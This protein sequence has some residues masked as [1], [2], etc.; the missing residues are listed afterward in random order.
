MNQRYTIHLESFLRLSQ[1]EINGNIDLPFSEEL[2][3]AVLTI[4]KIC[5][6]ELAIRKKAQK[7]ESVRYFYNK[8]VDNRNDPRIMKALLEEFYDQAQ[9]I[10][11]D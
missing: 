11:N 2:D 4:N 3:K 8:L 6:Q 10:G 1:L 5:G 7:D 9:R